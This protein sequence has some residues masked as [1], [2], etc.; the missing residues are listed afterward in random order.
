MIPHSVKIPKKLIEVALPLDSINEAAAAEKNNPFIREHPRNLHLWWAR[1]P[2]AA[3]RAVIFGQLVNDPSWKW[4]LEF[5]GKVPPSNLKASWAASR[6][7][8]F[9]L[10]GQL[11]KWENTTNEEVLERAR[12][13]IRKSWRETCELNQAHPDAAML[14]SP[15]KL[16]GLHDPFCGGG[17]IPLEASRLGLNALASDLNP[18]SVLINTAMIDVPPRFM[19]ITPIGPLPQRDKVNRLDLESSWPNSKGLAEDVRR[20]GLWLCDKARKLIGDL[21]PLVEIT[22]EVIQERPDLKPFLGQKLTVI[23]WLWARTVKSPNPAFR[24]VDVPLATTFI[25]STKGEKETYVH[26]II[27][28]DRYRFTVKSEKQA[29]MRRTGQNYPEEQIS[30][31]LFLG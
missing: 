3:A 4:E 30:G 11:V 17:A 31:A 2:L 16:P 8:L 1:R 6:K 19:G 25:L 9:D 10:L 7:R 26:P 13:E 12:A 29:L 28:A 15:A 24:H 23:A 18:V 20:Y 22:A 14:F 5:P 27:T 21:Y